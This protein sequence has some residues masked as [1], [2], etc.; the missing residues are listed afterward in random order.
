VSKKQAGYCK[1][2]NAT[3]QMA[4]VAFCEYYPR[5]F[6][7]LFDKLYISSIMKESGNA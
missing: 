1:K 6:G 7:I 3:L 2:Y 5:V 4:K